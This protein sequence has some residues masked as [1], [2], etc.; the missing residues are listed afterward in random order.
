MSIYDCTCTQ[1]QCLHIQ[2]VHE[3]EQCSVS[4]FVFCIDKAKGRP[5][6]SYDSH[7]SANIGAD[8]VLNQYD[9]DNDADNQH[10]S[11]PWTGTTT[12]IS[13]ITQHLSSSSSLLNPLSGPGDEV[14]VLSQNQ[15]NTENTK[16]I[17]VCN[18]EN[19]VSVADAQSTHEAK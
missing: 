8:N 18:S 9:N 2:I 14:S 17:S 10:T 13:Q 19:G 7:N 1:M 11:Q 6:Q 16:L 5:A 12:T 3:R 15:A 4:L